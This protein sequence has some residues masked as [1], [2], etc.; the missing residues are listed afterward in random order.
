MDKFILIRD[1]EEP[2]KEKWNY[3]LAVKEE[4]YEAVNKIVKESIDSYNEREQEDFYIGFLRNMLL[5]N[6]FKDVKITSEEEF[7]SSRYKY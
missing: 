4:E 5:R 3:V 6:G 2:E 7:Y 1:Y